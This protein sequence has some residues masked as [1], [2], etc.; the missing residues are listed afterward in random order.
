METIIVII[1]SLVAFSWGMYFLYRHKKT[2]KELS[3]IN[4]SNFSIEA[5]TVDLIY[6][7]EE[8][9]IKGI[10]NQITENPDAVLIAWFSDT[11]KKYN[12]VL[13]QQAVIA[14][15]VT[16]SMVKDKTVI[17]LERHPLQKK[18]FILIDRLLPAKVIY[19]SSLD[20]PLLKIAGGDR[21]KK[22]MEK[23]GAQPDEVITHSLISSSLL[24][25]QEE[26]E[27]KMLSDPEVNSAEEW[28]I[29]N[30]IQNIG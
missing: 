21:V 9:K 10:I 3:E 25:A 5:Q 4:P 27:K 28:F 6:M 23:L 19:I 1:F 11:L 17:M 20:D 22:M 26:I 2:Y 29:F 14:L 24:R 8:A 16:S 7:S 13:P 18:E 15:D 12:K 30:R